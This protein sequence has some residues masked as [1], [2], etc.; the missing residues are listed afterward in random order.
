M[1]DNAVLVTFKEIIELPDLMAR[2]S[3]MTAAEIHACEQQLLPNEARDLDLLIKAET[4]DDFKIEKADPKL[5]HE[6]ICEALHQGLSDAWTPDQQV[7]I[8]AFLAD[9]AMG[10]SAVCGE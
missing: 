3:K 2:Y 6:L 7:A 1:Q 4:V 9:I 5:V 8:R 10:V